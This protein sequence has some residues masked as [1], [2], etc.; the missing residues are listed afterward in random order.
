[1][2]NPITNGAEKHAFKLHQLINF[3]CIIQNKIPFAVQ[4]VKEFVLYIHR[5]VILIFTIFQILVVDRFVPEESNQSKTYIS[6]FE[7]IAI[8]DARNTCFS[9]RYTWIVTHT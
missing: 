8:I 9:L 6:L 3:K 7:I 4:Y 2:S 5:G 1:M